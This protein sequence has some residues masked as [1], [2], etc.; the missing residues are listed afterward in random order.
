VRL[1]PDEISRI[2]TNDGFVWDD[3]VVPICPLVELLQLPQPTEPRPQ[4]RLIVIAETAGRIAG[5]E[6]EAI[7]DRLDVVLKPIPDLLAGAPC[8]AGTTLLGDG[9]VLLVLDLKEIMP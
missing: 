2:K 8:Y 7:R 6:V 9:A 4:V 5:L 1:K 3:R